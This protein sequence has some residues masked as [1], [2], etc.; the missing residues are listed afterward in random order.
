MSGDKVRILVPP[1]IG[2]IYWV[3]VKL[4]AFLKRE[5]ITARPEITAVSYESPDGV[6]LRGIQY[7]KLFDW[8]DVADPPTIP[9]DPELQPI[10]DEAYLGPGRSIFPGVMGYDYFIAYNGRINSGGWLEGDDL[11]CE[12]DVLKLDFEARAAQ[13]KEAIGEKYCVHFWPFYGSYTSHLEQFGLDD[14]VPSL[15]LMPKMKHVFIGAAWERELNPRVFEM[16]ERV[17][18]S[19]DLIGQ[20]EL[21]DT[22]QLMAGAEMIV[23][24]HAG[25]TNLAAAFG[26]K[27]VLLW[28]DRYPPSTCVA[29]VPPKTRGTNYLPVQTKGLT[30]LRLANILCEHLAS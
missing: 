9:N 17:S 24:Y 12:W 5:G 14:I 23:G 1:G 7:L 8:L 13:W 22:I 29:C 26:M 16:M 20:T 27:T 18:N 15:Y 25:M 4:R 28:D 3:L 10:W 30:R 11:D 6:H 2:D 19:V 21:M